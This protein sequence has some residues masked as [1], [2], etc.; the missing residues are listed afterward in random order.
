M[1]FEAI[2]A[3]EAPLDMLLKHVLKLLSARA[4]AR[5]VIPER[6]KKRW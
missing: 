5:V 3:A 1:H 2:S 6:I 4:R